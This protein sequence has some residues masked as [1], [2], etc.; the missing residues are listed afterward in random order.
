[1]GEV[2]EI[3]LN[4]S[5][6]G[7]PHGVRATLGRICAFALV[8]LT[9][10]AA[11][12]GAEEAVTL[13]L[14]WRHAFQFAGIYAA[15]EQGYYR[16]EGLDVHLIEGGPGGRPIEHVLASQGHY[17]IAD[18]G[19]LI[20]RSQGR[21]VR[22]I[23][24][25]FQHSP[26]VLLALR[27]S[28][29]RSFADLR[30]K[31]IMLQ[32][33]L[34][35]DILAALRKA[36]LDESSFIRQQIS[37]DIHDLIEGKTD[38]YAAY[39]TDQPHQLDKLG[40]GYRVLS[41]REEGIDFYGDLLITSDEEVGQHPDRVRRMIRATVRGWQY[42]LDHPQEIVDLILKKYN[43]QHFSADQLQFEAEQTARMILKDIVS[44]G[45]MS[46]Y[47]W[48]KIADTYEQLRL[49][50]AGFDIRSLL[51]RPRPSLAD[52]LE[53]YRWQLMVATLLALLLFAGLQVLMLRRMVR[54]RTERLRESEA[55]F[56]TLVE[57][58]PGAIFRAKGDGKQEIDFISP[59]IRRISG[60]GDEDLQSGAVRFGSF[61]HPDD[62]VTLVESV[63]R[64]VCRRESY[65]LEYRLIHRNGGERWVLEKGQPVFDRQGHLRHIDGSIFDVGALRRAEQWR[66]D[67]AIILEMI[68]GEADASDIFHR[69]VETFE[70]RH[71]GVF[72]SI[73]MVRDDR[74]YPVAAPHLPREY[75][76]LCTGLRI[77]PEGCVCTMAAFR[78]E[79]VVIEDIT[80]GELP[81][82]WRKLF[83]SF[84]MRSCWAEPFFDAEGRVLGVFAI[85][86]ELSGAP[87]EE[88]F[89]DIEH[90]SRLA[91]IAAARERHRQR[92][93]M[94]SLA[95]EQAND[96]VMVVDR[97]CRI[98]YLNPAFCRQVGSPASE[99]IGMAVDE[100]RIEQDD[101]GE[102]GWVWHFVLDG[103][104]WAGK[105]RVRRN[106]DEAWPAMLSVSPLRNSEGQVTH[107]V[108]VLQDLAE[109]QSMEEQ[110][111][112]AQKMESIGVL[113]GGIAHNFNNMLAALYGSIELAKM[114]AHDPD[115]VMQWLSDMES[116]AA[117]G[118]EIVSKMLAFARKDPVRFQVSSLSD[119]MREVE[120]MARIGVGEHIDL[121]F[122]IPD[123]PAL[124][125][126]DSTQIEQ[127]LLNLITNAV[128]AV[129]HVDAPRIEAGL[130]M[131]VGNAAGEAGEGA[132]PGWV[133]L[134][135]RDN[136]EGIPAER[137][138]QIFDPFFTT[139]EVGKGSGL[140]LAMVYGTVKRHC[141][142][143]SVESEVGR[144]SCFR[145]RLPAAKACMP[146]SETEPSEA[147][148]ASVEP[149]DGSGAGILVAD[150]DAK[151]RNVIRKVL[152]RRGYR[153]VEAENGEQAWH[154]FARHQGDLAAAVLDMV[155][156]RMSGVEAAIRMREAEPDFPILFVSGYD[157]HKG[158]SEVTQWPRTEWL[159]KPFAVEK[160]ERHLNRL[161][162]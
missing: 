32:P 31:R 86:R 107:F 71:P 40:I 13:Q 74:L 118:A 156:P 135:V 121:V 16:A 29:I 1:M 94:L 60:Y 95:I 132:H 4:C 30:G 20:A 100:L 101:A 33:G 103:N 87:C 23:A 124:I 131:V 99:L 19:V 88:E 76:D 7:A 147:V 68:A 53:Q 59:E 112:Q 108:A 102:L 134:T 22:V 49:I 148:I 58:I 41:P 123:E 127:V 25:I 54:R 152:E 85:Y 155:M 24:A 137:M 63:R 91:S 114:D 65:S 111:R 106:H 128:D 10:I 126:M 141:G 150:D 90:A 69:I 129:E 52:I 17:A 15:I 46:D 89:D 2:L 110:L 77:A 157:L 146:E 117:R 73:L 36:G 125:R 105:V 93:R 133:E 37:Y 6:P 162:R 130:R 34:N 144:G 50:P 142:E 104:S 5:L 161:L 67:S 48:R 9:A 75:R 82:E 55:R 78:K 80:E 45:Y 119:L 39:L 149:T 159:A 109:I 83:Q 143:I 138:E 18:T 56:R 14:K 84:S 11:P 113:A 62:Q 145:I 72:A 44:I 115:Q 122:D 154:A 28:G 136:G 61:V 160:M 151:V 66:R 140:G 27:D 42:A 98:E 57:N 47:R 153:V 38:A 35:T 79:R 97:D 8:L 3:S 139:K 26:L 51:Y 92:L 70:C 21:K 64:A 12:A 81:L 120:D 158:A 43:T 116:M 96:L